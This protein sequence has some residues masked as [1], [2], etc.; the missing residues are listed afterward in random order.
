MSDT[1]VSNLERRAFLIGIS[2]FTDDSIENL[3]HVQTDI[4]LLST[5]LQSSDASKFDIITTSGTHCKRASQN[6]IFA[7]LEQFFASP[8]SNTR[9]NL[10]YIASHGFVDTNGILRIIPESFNSDRPLSTSIPITFIAECL[11]H[12]PEDSLVLILDCCYADAASWE[13]LRNQ[14]RPFQ[15]RPTK[16]KSYC[17]IASCRDDESALDG[18]FTPVFAE[19]LKTLEP[20][21]GER[22]GVN[23]ERVFDYTARRVIDRYGQTPKLWSSRSST[24]PLG[25]RYGGIRALRSAVKAI[26]DYLEDHHLVDPPEPNPYNLDFVE[27]RKTIA[28]LRN[29]IGIRVFDNVSAADPIEVV[30]ESLAQAVQNDVIDNGIVVVTDATELERLSTN[31]VAI[32]SFLELR[33]ELLPI[34]KYLEQCVEDYENAP[35]N[36]TKSIYRK[37]HYVSLSAYAEGQQDHPFKLDDKILKWAE[38]DGNDRILTILGE[39]GAGKTTT[40]HF[41]FW[42]QSKRYL[43]APT[44]ERL[45]VLINLR[46]FNKRFDMELLVERTVSQGRTLHQLSY[47]SIA[48]LNQRGRILW[49][50]DGFDEMAVRV[51]SQDMHHNFSEILKLS[52]PGSKLVLTCRTAFFKNREEVEEVLGSSQSLHEQLTSQGKN[53]YKVLYIKP[54]SM[55]EIEVFIH[56]RIRA[57]NADTQDSYLD[58]KEFLAKLNGTPEIRN[59]ASRPILLEMILVTLPTLIEQ[60]IELNLYNLYDQYTTLL[61]K[62]DAWRFVT[63]ILDNR[64]KF[65]R[66]LAW[67][68][69]ETNTYQITYRELPDFIKQLFPEFARKAEEFEQLERA[70]RT[71]SFLARDEAGNF[72]FAHKS[73]LEFFAA[74]N[75]IDEL[76]KGNGEALS[77]KIMPGEVIRFAKDRVKDSEII[78]EELNRI[79]EKSKFNIFF[80][81]IEYLKPRMIPVLTKANIKFYVQRQRGHLF[82]DLILPFIILLVL[83]CYL[84]TL[85]VSIIELLKLSFLLPLILV[86]TAL[87]H[88]LMYTIKVFSGSVGDPIQRFNSFLLQSKGDL[89]ENIK[90][91]EKISKELTANDREK[92]KAVISYLSRPIDNSQDSLVMKTQTQKTESKIEEQNYWSSILFIGCLS[93]SIGILYYMNDY[94]G[95][96]NDIFYLL[97]AGM[98]GCLGGFLATLQ[99][100]LNKFILNKLFAR[101]SSKFFYKKNL[102]ILCAWVFASVLGF[103]LG[104]FGETE[105][106]N[107]IIYIWLLI[108]SF[109]GAVISSYLWFR[110]FLL[111]RD[112]N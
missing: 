29:R 95:Y 101:F 24:I 111:S 51:T 71:T 103:G 67:Y 87:F 15:I 106:G 30:I 36:T 5:V 77:E 99:Y 107:N 40:S 75:I 61:L 63:N 93:L 68:F 57:K 91:I 64:V 47:E 13:V 9:L 33:R 41:I 84:A 74:T 69:F 98:L 21:L 104:N 16:A 10:V 97:T 6:E 31:R 110:Y 81:F 80:F 52:S 83:G 58:P 17:V 100:L 62:R 34:I 45:P 56:S 23:V 60:G 109:S 44:H 11:Q 28:G 32:R 66:A 37:G 54:L 39:F 20:E 70:I 78:K 46:E 7:D 86:S 26:Y 108:T 89:S 25:R 90:K 76:G 49:I 22:E 65:C 72:S 50:L 8:G 43:N 96:R 35:D 18:G 14:Q 53:Q 1:S 27:L 73:F 85:K 82:F 4:E 2:Q 12:R 42:Q 112:K 102:D 59:L 55:A 92:A 19:A 88:F 38:L 94:Y 48:R 105:I 3:P 79:L